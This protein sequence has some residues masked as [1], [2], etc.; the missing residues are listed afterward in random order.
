MKVVSVVIITATL[1]G[2]VGIALGE[3]RDRE[4]LERRHRMAPTREL[5]A[6]PE[7]SRAASE[8]DDSESSK[9]DEYSSPKHDKSDGRGDR[10]RRDDDDDE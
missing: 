4:P 10:S 6:S 2:V 3:D 7:R 8:R 1:A 5:K 9:P